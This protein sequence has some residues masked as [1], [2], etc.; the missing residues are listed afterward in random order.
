[1]GEVGSWGGVDERMEARK[2]G[3][4]GRGG[5]GRRRGCKGREKW[6]LFGLGFCFVLFLVFRCFIFL[7]F[8]GGGW[9]FGCFSGFVH[10]RIPCS[11]SEMCISGLNVNEKG[12]VTIVRGHS[13]E[14]MGKRTGRE[15]QTRG[16]QLSSLLLKIG[17][18]QA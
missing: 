6:R 11:V 5:E 13:S 17:L 10:Q 3:E 4:E 14:I 7:P 18:Q 16:S 8:W 12:R 15:K 2:E 9:G 1:M